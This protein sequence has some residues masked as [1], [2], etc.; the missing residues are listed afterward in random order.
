MQAKAQ[1]VR[2]PLFFAAL[3]FGAGVWAGTRMWRPALW[4]IGAML[5]FAAAAAYYRR[6]RPRTAVA[7]ALGMLAALGALGIQARD[8]G[9]S[10]PDV[11]RFTNGE[12]ALVT[13]HVVR[14]GLVRQGAFGDQRQSVDV[15]TEE[16]SRDSSPTPLKAGI[17]LTI[18]SR[19]N[20]EED[21]PADTQPGAAVPHGYGE[22]LRFAA[23]LRRP[24]NY[25]N[26]GALD[27]RGY[28][29]RQGIVALGSVRADRVEV[30]PGFA[31][32]R[33]AW[34]SS[35]VRRSVLAQIHALWPRQGPGLMDAM[36]IGERAYIGRDTSVDFQRTGVYHILVVSGMNVGIL[37]FVVFWLLKRMRVGEMG[38]SVATV[39]LSL[40]YAYLCEL[41][42]PIL[43]AVLMLAVFLGARLLYRERSLLNSVG[44]AA[45]VLLAVDPRALFDT[46]FQLTFVAVV[47]IAGIGL[48]LL[49][50]T[51]GPYRRALRNLDATAYDLSLA[52]RLAQWRLDL[53]LVLG[54]LGNS[55]G[56]R[57]SKFVLV[58]AIRAALATWDV[59]VISALMQVAMTL[60]MATYFHRATILALPAN[61]LVVPATG[62]LMPAATAA[63]A[64]AYI[65]TPLAK[66]PAIIA[67]VSLDVIT[68]TV[69]ILG[70]LRVAEVRVATPQLGMALIAA[71]TF[72]FA[73]WAA[74]RRALV[75]AS[76]LAALAAG[77]L[78]I[79]AVPPRPQ[80]QAAVLELT[81]IDV[82]QADSTLIVAPQGR[83]LLVDAAGSLGA[84]R[85]E[86][87]FGEDVIS[88]YLW[89]RGIVRL[90][91]VA[92]THAHA[93]HI[94]GMRAVLA[95]FRPRELWLGPNAPT[96]ALAALLEEA[97]RQGTR[98]V[99]RSGGDSFQFGGAQVRILS[100]PRD[101]QLAAKPRNN[102]SLVM[103]I[104]YQRTA[105]LLEGDAEQKM[106]REFVAAEPRADLL[107]VA[108]NGSATSTSPELLRALRPKFAVISVGAQNS[109]G[110]P[111]R[112][113]LSRLAA[114]QA[115]TY[116]T[117]ALGAVTFYLDGRS[118]TP[119]PGAPPP[120]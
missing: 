50:R 77:A 90:D 59:L 36:L 58:R 116:R 19:E 94:G 79:T 4:W 93:D 48:P 6:R 29:A 51:S 22:R 95:N 45:L 40:G 21:D 78:W 98:I 30:L 52:P 103:E 3:A 87:D 85:S 100:P 65:W 70:H 97:G 47:A 28:L 60:P 72:V 41:G 86:F 17:R 34:W 109:F 69:R 27:Y 5:V 119:K 112:E 46:S 82:G 104:S 25:G 38:A 96:P 12:Q 23:K 54:R 8:A 15:E 92:L 114:A 106:E 13:A 37:A 105:A 2:Q 99:R 32:S 80:L 108:H 33:L 68:G 118:V 62:L 57:A 102:D 11:S 61:A 63:V 81:A 74:R 107:K 35:R 26:P 14:D 1:S 91:A 9:S 10:L 73:M 71:A 24:R 88:P 67:G 31:G 89:S 16:I 44:A 113:V 7:L 55:F 83:T 101:W 75:A 20:T 120:R 64:L 115:A 53:R 76:G 66:I 110:H 117:D 49:E 84:W 42:A 39:L 18:Y 56:A 43:R 111:R